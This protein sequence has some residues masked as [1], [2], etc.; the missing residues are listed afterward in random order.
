[1]VFYALVPV[2]VISHQRTPGRL[3]VTSFPG[4]LQYIPCKGISYFDNSFWETIKL[5][6]T[7]H[8]HPQGNVVLRVCHSVRGGGCLPTGGGGLGRPPATRKA[9]G[10]HP[11]GM[12]SCLLLVCE[13]ILSCSLKYILRQIKVLIELFHKFKTRSVQ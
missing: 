10:T 2:H 6:G 5:R 4:T 12:L 13:Q 7:I 3:V 8:Y 11:T 9:G 1:M